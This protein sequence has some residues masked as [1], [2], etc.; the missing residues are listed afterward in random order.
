MLEK[1]K[2]VAYV[3]QQTTAD[4]LIVLYAVAVVCPCGQ[5][6]GLYVPL[7]VRHLVGMHFASSKPGEA[8]GSIERTSV[9]KTRKRVVEAGASATSV[10]TI[11]GA[12]EHH[13]GG[14]NVVV[15]G[16][17]QAEVFISDAIEREEE[18]A[19]NTEQARQDLTLWSTHNSLI[20]A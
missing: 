15:R 10:G 7:Y 19:Y 11:H 14:V 20:Y 6:P 8:V 17:Y 3:G 12:S 9:G 1:P 2:A 5:T 18:N 4:E 13:D 16:W